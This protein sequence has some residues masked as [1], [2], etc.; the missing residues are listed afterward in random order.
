MYAMEKS[1]RQ[2]LV[3]LKEPQRLSEEKTGNYSSGS[4]KFLKP[5]MENT[6]MNIGTDKKRGPEFNGNIVGTHSRKVIHG[7]KCAQ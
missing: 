3:D 4:N 6:Q 2:E 5:N 7:C 1:N